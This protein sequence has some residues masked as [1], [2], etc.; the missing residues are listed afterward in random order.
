MKWHQYQLTT[1]P[2]PAPPAH[3]GP[4]GLLKSPNQVFVECQQGRLTGTHRQSD[5]VSHTTICH[6][7]FPAPAPPSVLSMEPVCPS[8]HSAPLENANAHTFPQP[9]RRSPC[10]GSHTLESPH[11]TNTHKRNALK[12]TYAPLSQ[13]SKCPP[14]LKDPAPDYSSLGST[15]TFLHILGAI[16]L[17]LSKSD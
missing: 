6:F 16:S 15:E 13:A 4:P 8:A 12:H 3:T 14:A 1:A 2:I 5:S 9:G 11:T 7:F 10:L 17:P